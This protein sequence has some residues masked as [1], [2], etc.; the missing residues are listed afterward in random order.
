MQPN[1]GT[2]FQRRGWIQAL[3]DRFFLLPAA[4]SGRSATVADRSLRSQSTSTAHAE[5]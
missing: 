5:H 1:S 2:R 4:A 3:S